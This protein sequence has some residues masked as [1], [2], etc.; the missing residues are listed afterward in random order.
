[1]SCALYTNYDEASQA[2]LAGAVNTESTWASTAPACANGGKTT[3]FF[4]TGALQTV[5]SNALYVKDIFSTSWMGVS[6]YTW[7]ADEAISS[8]TCGGY[9]AG[10]GVDSILNTQEDGLGSREPLWGAWKTNQK[11]WFLWEINYWNDSNNGGQTQNGWN[12]NTANDNNMYNIS[13]NFGY[14]SFPTTSTIK[15]H[16]GFGFTN[17]DGNMLYPATDVVYANPSFG[18]NGVVGSWKLNMLT[19]GIQDYDLIKMAYTVNPAS[20]TA[21]VNGQVQDIMYLR[22][23]FT[24]SD[25]TYS[26]GP[27]PWN[28]NENSW[29]TARE[30]LYQIIAG[31]PATV[32][33]I[34]RCNGPIHFQGKIIF[35]P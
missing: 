5:L 9:N 12:A 6:S 4:Q 35:T 13:K 18:F 7:I 20:T 16:F 32:L 28:Q 24:L 2:N 26:Y 15:G 8:Y 1:L 22:Q 19:R 27:R 23:C 14:D 25:C 30:Q 34:E 29:E 10:I 3:P 31:A 11:M 21:I 17:G 33:P